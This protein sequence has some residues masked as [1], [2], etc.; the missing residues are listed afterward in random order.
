[1]AGRPRLP[2]F[3]VPHDAGDAEALAPVLASGQL[4]GGPLVAA[5]EARLAE[6]QEAAACLTT[7]DG[8]G[9]LAIALRLA[10]VEA[11][12]EVALSPLTC[13]ATAMPV[14][15]V[16]ARPLWLDVDPRTGMPGADHLLAAIGPRTKAVIAYHWAGDLPDLAALAETCRSRGIALIQDASEAWGARFGGRPLGGFGDMTILSF[17]ATRALST[18]DG[19]A[20]LLADPSRLDRARRLRRFGIEQRGFRLSSGDLNPD[21]DIAEASGNH[22][23]TSIAAALG[24]RQFGG[25]AARVR[26]HQENGRFYDAALRGVAGLTLL[27]RPDDRQ[28]AYW[29]Y[30]LRAERRDDLVR[31]LVERGIG[32]QRLHVRVDA[33]G[34]FAEHRRAGLAG[35]DLFDRE[36]IAI[37]C[38]WWLDDAG[39]DDIVRCLKSGW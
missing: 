10:G 23:M 11:G 17:Y 5:F 34:C 1:M 31:R 12:D 39:R 22:Q 37:P 20:L 3:G 15:G 26:R 7:A 4:A 38:G 30:A 19:G 24:L 21:S 36:N 28:S 9:A 25:V 33:Y 8:S 2:L 13:T 32:A 35:V 16:G 29:T 27:A 18:G 6:E 14:A